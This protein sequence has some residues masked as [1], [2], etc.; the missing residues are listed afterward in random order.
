[1]KVYSSSWFCFY[2]MMVKKNWPQQKSGKCPKPWFLPLSKIWKFARFGSCPQSVY[3]GP[4]SSSSSFPSITCTLSYASLP[5]LSFPFFRHVSNPRVT[6]SA[7][8]SSPSSS[9]SLISSS[10]HPH[11]Y[12]VTLLLHSGFVDNRVSGEKHL[13]TFDMFWEILLCTRHHNGSFWYEKNDF[14]QGGKALAEKQYN[15]HKKLYIASL[16]I[17]TFCAQWKNSK[18]I[19]QYSRL[20]NVI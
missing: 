5:Q 17:H 8:T 4:S 10:A 6:S 3:Q 13:P 15:L 16:H 18:K 2:Y 7:L 1:M 11:H 19:Y 20:T 14:P 12:L 9:S